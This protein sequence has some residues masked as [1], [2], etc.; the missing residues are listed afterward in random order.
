M[1]WYFFKYEMLYVKKNMTA[2]DTYHDDSK[3]FLNISEKLQE[4]L[5]RLS[6]WRYFIELILN[7]TMIEY[8]VLE[9]DCEQ[10]LKEILPKQDYDSYKHHHRMVLDT[11]ISAVENPKTYESAEK[12]YKAVVGEAI[13]KIGRI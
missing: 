12:K 3:T 1:A 2:M 13:N 4:G 11:L 6:L 7:E 8:N 5:I 9:R 10:K